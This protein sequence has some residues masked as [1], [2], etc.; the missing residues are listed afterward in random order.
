[1]AIDTASGFLSV[2]INERVG[3]NEIL[4]ILM[5]SRKQKPTSLQGRLILGAADTMPSWAWMQSRV[6][7]TNVQVYSSQLGLEKMKLL[8]T[9]QVCHGDGDDL[10]LGKGDYLSWEDMSWTFHGTVVTGEVSL[11][12]FCQIETE[13]SKP[14]LTITK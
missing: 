12:T 3:H 11:H 8:T 7:V 4:P 5:D 9:V 6:K 14:N 13:F 10:S 1:M 2:V